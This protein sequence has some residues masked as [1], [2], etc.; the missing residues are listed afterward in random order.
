M[1]ETILRECIRYW[2]SV[3][4]DDSV[5]IGPES[6]LMEDLS[7]SS[8]E[9]L[10]ALMSLENQYRIVIP[11]RALRKV[12]TVGDVARLIADIVERAGKSS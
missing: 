3:I 4:A 12:V 8:L 1:Y 2:E 11:E 6:D 5:K 9:M 7:A 10:T